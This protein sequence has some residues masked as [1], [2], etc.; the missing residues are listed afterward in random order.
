MNRGPE[1]FTIIRQ[2]I[3]N[4]PIPLNP[5]FYNEIILCRA[6]L[7]HWDRVTDIWVRKLPIICS[8]NGL[9]PGR[10]QA[11][12]WNNYGIFL[13]GHLVKKRWNPNRKSYISIQEK[14]FKGV[15]CEMAAISSRPQGVTSSFLHTR[16]LINVSVR[17]ANTDAPLDLNNAAQVTPLKLR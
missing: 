1:H 9:S 17:Y 8:D 3:N 14:A 12:I 10:R 5:L 11:I 4:L 13:I 15:V 16:K 7:I 2:W 6:Y